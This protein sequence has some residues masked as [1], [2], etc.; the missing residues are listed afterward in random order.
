MKRT[1]II[2]V[3]LVV[4]LLISTSCTSGISQDEY[5]R[6][7]NE[8]STIQS[9]LASLQSK[10][11]ESM[12]LQAQSEVLNSKLDTL[13]GEYEVLQTKYEELIAEYDELSGDYDNVQSEFKAMQDEYEELSAKYEELSKQM[14]TVVEEE[15]VVEIIEED[16]EQA[17]FKLVNQ[18]RRDNG[19]NE[20]EWSDLLHKWAIANSRNMATNTSYEYSS[21]AGWQDIF[22]AIGYDT[23]DEIAE[24]ALTVWRTSLIY[25][26]NIL[27]LITNYGTVAVHKSGEIYYITYIASPL[28]G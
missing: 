6:V 3:L 16:V 8:L 19:L 15:E 12:A 4:I 1:G 21:Y 20:L 28:K 13:Q 18:E 9:E 24:A 22:W 17:V 14:E 25:D 10:L 5:D 7:K 2:S 26:K 27:N 11:T 23:A